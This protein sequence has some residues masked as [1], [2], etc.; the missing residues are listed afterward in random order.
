MQGVFK[1]VALGGPEQDGS[2]GDWRRQRVARHTVVAPHA[3]RSYSASD[4][5][6]HG[7]QLVLNKDALPPMLQATI[8]TIS[9]QAEI[10]EIRL[11][12]ATRLCSSCS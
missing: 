4:F 6:K 8:P 10:L 3:P 7:M 9:A 2:T 1:V 12:Q 11:T 5:Q